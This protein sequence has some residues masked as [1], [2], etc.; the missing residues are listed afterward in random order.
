M[1]L[2]SSIILYHP[3]LN[4]VTKNINSY[5]NSVDK[6][7]II[8]NTPNPNIEI[9]NLLKISDKIE[10]HPNYDNF[11]IAKALNIAC[12][13][14]IKDGFDWI[15]TFDQDSWCFPNM[16]EVL[17]Q[18]ASNHTNVGSVSPVYIPSIEFLEESKKWNKIIQTREVSCVITSGCLTNLEAYKIANGFDEIY[19]I[20]LVDID[21]SFKL[22]E[23]G[24]NILVTNEVMMIHSLGES[25][26]F[27]LWKDKKIWY[28]NHSPIRRYYIT[29]NRLYFIKKYNHKY[30]DFCKTELKKMSKE[31]AKILLFESQKIPKI[32][33]IFYGFFDF[34]RGISGKTD[35]EF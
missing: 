19:F 16:I 25:N 20:D 6:L 3:D 24:Y 28:S 18:I 32:K 31:A 5:I 35:R 13:K 33:A 1:K 8:D 15:I 34:Y 7:Y 29:R 27:S 2:A 30:P 23:N 21:F 10:Y 22:R 17:K 11:G 9:E 14:A 26:F 4:E 12:N